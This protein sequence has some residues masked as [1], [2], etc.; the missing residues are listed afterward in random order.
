MLAGGPKRP[1]NFDGSAGG[2]LSLSVERGN[3]VLELS[4]VEKGEFDPSVVGGSRKKIEGELVS[5][6]FGDLGASK[7]DSSF[8][9]LCEA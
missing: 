1:D 7:T 4:V 3:E 9:S 8:G 2:L 5:C 6:V